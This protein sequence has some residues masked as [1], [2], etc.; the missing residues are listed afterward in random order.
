VVGLRGS[1][2]LTA[3]VTALS[4]VIVALRMR[5]TLRGKGGLQEAPGSKVIP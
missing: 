4:G 3:A 1:I 2:G 5:E